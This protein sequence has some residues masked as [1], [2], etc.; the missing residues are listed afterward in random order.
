MKTIW[1]GII[2][3]LEVGISETFRGAKLWRRRNGSYAT[4]TS[5]V[6]YSTAAECLAAAER[7]TQP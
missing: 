4:D 2:A 5:Y 3:N 6:S 7:Y 1:D